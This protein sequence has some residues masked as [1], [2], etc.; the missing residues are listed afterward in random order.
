MSLEISKYNLQLFRKNQVATKMSLA[1]QLLCNCISHAEMTSGRK[2]LCAGGW[3]CPGQGLNALSR[4]W[5][6][7]EHSKEPSEKLIEVT[8]SATRNGRISQPVK[9]KWCERLSDLRDN[10]REN[11]TPF[12]KQSL[13]R[14]A[15]L[16]WLLMMQLISHKA[17]I[18][19]TPNFGPKLGPKGKR[20]RSTLLIWE[21]VM[22]EKGQ[23][24][25]LAEP[26]ARSPPF[27][28]SSC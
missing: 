15:V 20:I 23:H 16:G 5:V 26:C 17:E 25:C 9:E 11:W 14:P 6:A 2:L 22:A 4:P 21:G 13:A 1:W 28:L 19:E 24:A 12:W 7:A 8:D 27:S 18:T 10:Q 3:V